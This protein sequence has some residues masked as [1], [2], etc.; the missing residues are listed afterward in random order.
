MCSLRCIRSLFASDLGTTMEAKDMPPE[1]WASHDDVQQLLAYMLYMPLAD[2]RGAVQA[3]LKD[4]LRDGHVHGLLR[5][6]APM[7]AGDWKKQKW[8]GSRTSS[9][10]AAL[11]I[12]LYHFLD[13]HNEKLVPPQAPYVQTE[14]S[15]LLKKDLDTALDVNFKAAVDA[16]RAADRRSADGF[17]SRV[18]EIRQAPFDPGWLR[19]RLNT[20]GI[21]GADSGGGGGGGGG[22]SGTEWEHQTASLYAF[23]MGTH[24]RLGM[25]YAARDEPG[26]VPMLASNLD[27]L[28]LVAS[29]VRGSTRPIFKAPGSSRSSSSCNSMYTLS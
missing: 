11:H 13:G 1:K 26:V 21:S 6:L 2:H 8:A 22:G 7:T 4:D 5:K 17:A 24:E 18:D 25:G 14:F 10:A 28:R 27:V 16:A 12:W 19:L 9:K 3:V 15:R 23:A 29:F 20:P